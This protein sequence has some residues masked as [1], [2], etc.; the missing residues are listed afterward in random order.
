MSP[1]RL[2]AAL[3]AMLRPLQA[4]TAA[5]LDALE[6][7]ANAIRLAI[8]RQESRAVRALRVA[9]LRDAEITVFSQGGE[10]GI[11]QYLVAHVPIEDRSFVELGVDTYEE[12]NTR[13]LLES[14]NWRGRIVDGGDAHRRFVRRRGLD[15][16]R[17]LDVVT[18]FVTRENAD[19][20]VRAG[21]RAGDLGLLSIDIDG[22]DYWVLEAIESVRP[23][24]LIVEY[25]SVFGAEHAITVPYDPAFVR[26]RAHASHLYYG[27][28][29]PALC[30]LAASKGYA[31]VGSN[32]HGNNAFFVREDLAGALPRPTPRQAWVESR[33][34]ESRAPDGSLTL[35]GPHAER[36]RIIADCRVV[37]LERGRETTLRELFGIRG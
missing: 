20:L 36:R 23:R 10:D 18:A 33:Y 25:N 1:S 5:R 37:D 27:A 12:S 22:N 8:G 16:R 13:F 19:A 9:D 35:V 7:Q 6:A 11:I 31:F 15:W 32:S 26:G 17:D 28:S 2:V 34:R 30:R 4:E 24:I 21:A 29:L 14:E 3:T